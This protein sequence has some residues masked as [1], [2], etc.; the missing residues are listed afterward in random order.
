MR[1][2]VIVVEMQISKDLDSRGR[3]VPLFYLVNERHTIRF[4]YS[5]GEDQR[6]T[7]ST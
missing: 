3:C 6:V 7:C 5:E 2:V 4:K 1:R